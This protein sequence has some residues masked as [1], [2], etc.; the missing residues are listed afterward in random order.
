LRGTHTTLQESESR[1]KEILEEIHQ[2]STSPIMVDTQIYH[3]VTFL[4]DV[5]DLE[6]EHQLMG[7]TSICVPKAADLHVEVYPAVRPGST[8]QHESTED[9]MS[10]P[11]HTVVSDISQEHAEMYGGIHR[12]VLLCREDTHLGEH[13]YATPWRQHIFMRPHIHHFRSSI[14]DERWRLVDQQLEELLLVV[15]DDWGLVM[16]TG[17][18]LSGVQVDVLLA[19]SLGLTEAGGIFQSY[20]QL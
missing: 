18:Q 10:M 7:D 19:K 6:E 15:P 12:G 1:T 4:G 5:D 17:E 2:R 11:K 14:R 20:G 16:A 3:S 9:D 8:M 13:A